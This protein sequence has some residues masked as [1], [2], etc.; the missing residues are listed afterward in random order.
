MSDMRKDVTENDVPLL[1]GRY[2]LW[3]RLGKRGVFEVFEAFDHERGERALMTFP[4][5]AAWDNDAWQS[6]FF[7]VY[8][9]QM[10]LWGDH[11]LEFEDAVYWIDD[12]FWL[13]SS[14][15]EGST[16]R[17]LLESQ[18]KLHPKIAATIATMLARALNTAHRADQ[19][20][21]DVTPASIIIHK[22]G[23]VYLTDFGVSRAA[24]MAV[25]DKTGE[26]TDLQQYM[27]PEQHEGRLLAGDKPADLYGFGVTLYECLAGGTPFAGAEDPL[28]AKRAKEYAP[29]RERSPEVDARLTALV[30]KCLEPDPKQRPA[31]F[32][33]VLAELREVLPEMRDPTE[34]EAAG[35]GTAPSPADRLALLKDAGVLD[36]EY[37]KARKKGVRARI[38][39][40]PSVGGM[41]R[42][43]GGKLSVPVLIGL[44]ALAL[45]IVA[46]RLFGEMPADPAAEAHRP[47]LEN[48]SRDFL[49]DY[50]VP[51]TTPSALAEPSVRR[52]P[53][54]PA[55][56]P[57]PAPAKLSLSEGQQRI[58]KNYLDAGDKYGGQKRYDDAMRAY[59]NAL[60]LDP[61]NTLVLNRMG[62]AHFRKRQY[63]TAIQYYSKALQA[64]PNYATAY[65]NRGWAYLT[66]GKTADLRNAV[67][68]YTSGL[69]LDPKN[70]L[71]YANRG[72]C[73][74]KLGKLEEAITDYKK[75][76]GL[77]PKNMTARLN[78]AYAYYYKQDYD[79]AWKALEEMKARG[80]K[81]SQSLINLLAQKT[82]RKRL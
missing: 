23:W 42:L 60:R 69:Q 70:D 73:Y 52:E 33:A 67:A 62:V 72:L 71:S 53:L 20:H 46:W 13:V 68:D 64:D 47:T 15:V 4:P 24:K 31:D 78:L 5:R 81:P 39:R 74:R 55:E 11:V 40:M 48:W 57:K 37:V 36:A 50:R 66:K 75:A 63:D 19:L 26:R 32:D 41:P 8:V 2:E 54:R 3:R 22:S 29:I 35:K 17:E 65:F 44:P 45:V 82:S 30:D 10:A 25:E 6:Q 27:A 12:P 14:F 49:G 34:P 9:D 7:K 1:K 56:P 59:S 79:Q 77:A 21:R 51:R 58:V 43:G 61:D 76:I 38:P 16:L 18:R 80:G 28:K